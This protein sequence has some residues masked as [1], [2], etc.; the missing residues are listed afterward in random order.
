MR[1]HAEAK[2]HEAAH[3]GL[4]GLGNRTLLHDTAKA[5]L[6]GR[7][8]AGRRPRCCSSTSTTSRRSTTPS[9]TPPG[10]VFLQQVGDPAAGRRARGVRG[11]P[12]RRRRVRRAAERAA[13][14]RGRRPGRGA[15]APGARRTGRVRRPAAVGG[16]QRRRRV[17]P[18]GRLDVRRAAAAGRRRALP[19]E[20]LARLVHA[21]PRGQATTAACSAS[22]SPP[23]CGRRWPATSSSSTS[24]R[25]STSAAAPPSGP[26]RW[27]AGS[28][29]R[30][31]CSDPT[32]SSPPWSTPACCATSRCRCSR[33]P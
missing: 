5:L 6:D 9:A 4:T 3:D 21:L 23:S 14:G 13:V 12:A 26:R 16:G 30:A 15:A 25:S 18:A 32:T 28:T 7:P 20:V 8:R 24:S 1:T 2:A 31:G 33:R 10:D 17:P 19:G 11:L 22:R 29:R 27:S